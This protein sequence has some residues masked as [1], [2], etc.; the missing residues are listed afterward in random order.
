MQVQLARARGAARVIVVGR[1]YGR[2]ERARQLGAHTTISTLDADPLAAVRELTEGRGAD[3]TLESAGSAATWQMALALTRPGGT[4]VMFSGLPGGTEVPFDATRLHYGEITVKGC[5]H[6]TPRLVEQAL[7]L[8][9]AGVV[10]GAALIDG[11][12]DL[13]QVED[14]LQRMARS[15]AI[16]L[17]VNPRL[18]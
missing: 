3:V 15:E 1:A 9:A 17:A 4:A 13:A 12:I 2:L 14:G 7:E 18:A 8:L 16:K 10:D 6:H 5:F 11:Q